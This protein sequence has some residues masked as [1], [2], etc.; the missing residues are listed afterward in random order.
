MSFLKG[1][2]LITQNRTTYDIGLIQA[3]AYRVL[4]Q[5][6]AHALKSES[7][8]T[9]EWAMLG[10]ISHHVNGVRTTTIADELRVKPPLVSRLIAKAEAGGWI[11]ITQGVDKRERLVCLSEKA[12]RKIPIIEARIRKNLRPLLLGVSPRD[13]IGYLKTVASISENGSKLPFGSSDDYIPE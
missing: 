5:T 2:K 12:K 13:L 9:I 8:S 11:V 10:V 4:K 6:T 7:L 1:L 3:R